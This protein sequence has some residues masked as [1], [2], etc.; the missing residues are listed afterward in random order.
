LKRKWKIV[1]L[2][3]FVA[4][5]N[6]ADRASISVVFPQL[7]SEFHASDIALAAIGSVF[8]WAYAIGSPLAGYLADR[9]S[10]SHMVTLSL[11]TWS[12]I[13]ILSGLTRNIPQLL[14]TRALL[15]L[16]E[17]VYLPAALA[18]IGDHHTSDTRAT[19]MGIH[20]AGLNLG[21]IA[22]G[23]ASGYL[24]EH[25]GWRLNFFFLGSVGLLLAGVAHLV[26]RD[27][28][29]TS[30][31]PGFSEAS[32]WRNIRS[33]FKVPTVLILFAE[34]MLVSIGTWLFFN[35]LPLYF[36]E[37][38]SMSLAGAGFSST[39][40][41]QIAATIGLIGGGYLSDR[42]AGSHPNKRLLILGLFYLA[43][44]PF[45]L[46]FIWKAGYG[47][48]NTALFFYALFR[49]LGACNETPLIC[50]LLAPRLR[51]TA[52][53]LMNTA[54][55]FAAGCGILLSG[56]YK[57]KLGLSGIFGGVSLIL[58]LAALISI[59]GY[60]LFIQKDLRQQQD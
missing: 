49:A 24:A 2:L 16:A 28:P 11:L 53:G 51:S 32:L 44:A 8:L 55:C 10:R 26:L 47:G 27:G 3:F 37:R 23:V 42:V 43:A 4:A 39:F 5:V 41:L 52:F 17:C 18:L 25:F 56:Y 33:V 15:G 29:H 6:Y 21:L 9:F 48:I 38:F 20:L 30:F 58:L 46:A 19:A 50:D 7:R 13:T 59:M 22:G 36:E 60:L 12:V 40:M 34:A 1:I 35:W 45:L 57:Q 54:N 14:V 31:D